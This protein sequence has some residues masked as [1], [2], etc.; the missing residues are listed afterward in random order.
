MRAPWTQLY[1]HLVW[2]TW[3]RQPVLLPGLRERV[4]ECI[5]AECVGLR[6]DV[7]AIGG[8]ARI[9]LPPPPQSYAEWMA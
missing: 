3:D 6:V 2:A 1:L 4:Y 9:V 5:Q 7:I 8:I